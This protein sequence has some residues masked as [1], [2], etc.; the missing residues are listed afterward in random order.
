MII[1]GNNLKFLFIGHNA[2]PAG[3]QFLLL[4][5]LQWLSVN[6]KEI[7][8]H[9]LLMKPGP[10]IEAYKKTG[11][12][13]LFPNNKSTSNPFLKFYISLKQVKLIRRL[14][15]EEFDVIYSNTILNASILEKF[16]AFGVPI[17]THVHEMGLWFDKLSEKEVEI[18][19]N[20][21]NYFFTASKAVS[22]TLE[23][24]R[25]A[26][27][28][29]TYP[30]YV[31]ADD[32]IQLEEKKQFSLSKYLNLPT[33]AILVGACGSE[34][35]RKGKDWFLPISISVLSMLSH[36]NIHFVWIGGK[37]NSELEFDHLKSGYV[38]QIHFIDHL[39]HAHKYFHELSLFLMISREDPF[40]IVNIEAGFNAIPIL[41]FMNNGGTPEL[42]EDDLSLLVPYGNI[43]MMAKR[44]VSF[45]T[46]PHILHEKGKFIQSKIKNH[47]TMNHV[48]EII[49]NKVIEISNDFKN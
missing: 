23:E 34:N 11:K 13:Y 20:Y 14:L 38:D 9:I 31:F 32:Q 2:H 5:Y 19:K 22:K 1:C 12:L 25:I 6:R 3:A 24:L 17:I 28:E 16:G 43:A 21:T 46:D 18:L 29:E 10:L 41:S 45:L 27:L 47:Y 49:T 7:E 36:L 48:A 42:L 44:I 4:H 39:P 26:K 30:V 15:K 33:D 8:I 37:I 35:F 40:P